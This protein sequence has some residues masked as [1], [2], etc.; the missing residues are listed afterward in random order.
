VTAH[1]RW[2]G[3][4]AEELLRCTLG[5]ADEF[6]DEFDRMTVEQKAERF[7]DALVA[8]IVVA[9]ADSGRPTV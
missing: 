4:N 5:P 3:P 6:A 9:W 1:S 8:G 2:D 7:P